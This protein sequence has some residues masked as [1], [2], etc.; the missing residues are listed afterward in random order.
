MVGDERL[1]QGRGGYASGSDG[2]EG[3]GRGG[4]EVRGQVGERSRGGEKVE[5]MGGVG[6]GRWQGR[7]CQVRG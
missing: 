3:E 1:E 7:I 2:R 4:E 5:E 6:E